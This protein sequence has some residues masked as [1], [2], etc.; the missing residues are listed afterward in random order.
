MFKI[1]V[2]NQI[3]L[4]LISKVRIVKQRPRGTTK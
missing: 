4:K 2:T 3:A 1:I